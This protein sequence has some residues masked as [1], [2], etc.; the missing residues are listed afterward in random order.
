MQINYYLLPSHLVGSAATAL[1]VHMSAVDLSATYISEQNQRKLYQ[2]YVVY[3]GP[4][5]PPSAEFLSAMLSYLPFLL[6]LLPT[7]QIWRS[8]NY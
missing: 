3:P 2:K 6:P 4:L 7:L 5:F 1:T 8:Q